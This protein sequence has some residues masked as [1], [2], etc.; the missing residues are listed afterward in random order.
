MCQRAALPPA[1]RAIAAVSSSG[2]IGVG[3][4][5][6]WRLPRDWAHFAA[7]TRGGTLI[8][9]RTSHEDNGAAGLTGR[10]TVVVTT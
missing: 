9:G 2:V 6:P 7:T 3:G 1:V 10:A 8:L 5:L 4:R